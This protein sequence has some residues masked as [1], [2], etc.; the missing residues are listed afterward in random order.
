MCLAIKFVIALGAY[1]VYDVEVG[2]LV[3]KVFKPISL[4]R[5]T[6]NER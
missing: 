1:Y 3:A 4:G 6:L 2:K 5:G